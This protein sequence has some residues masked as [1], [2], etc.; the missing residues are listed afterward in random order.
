MTRRRGGKKGEISIQR[1][2]WELSSAI[3]SRRWEDSPWDLPAKTRGFY[4]Q[5]MW[6]GRHPLPFT[7]SARKGVLTHCQLAP[8]FTAITASVLALLPPFWFT[9][10]YPG[11]LC[12]GTLF[13]LIMDF[14]LVV[15]EGERRKRNISC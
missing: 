2:L 13:F 1:E 8:A 14:L 12:R 7:S 3:C 15:N 11:V 4:L 9:D 5:T 6:P 10:G